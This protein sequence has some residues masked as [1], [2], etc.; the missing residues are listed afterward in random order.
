[1]TPRNVVRAW[2]NIHFA[3]IARW[4]MLTLAGWLAYVLLR[5]LWTIVY[6]GVPIYDWLWYFPIIALLVALPVYMAWP[7]PRSRPV[8]LTFAGLLI[9]AFIGYNGFGQVVRLQVGRV[10][11]IP[12]SFWAYQD[13]FH[14]SETILKDLQAAGGC[15]YL[16]PGGSPFEGEHG[17]VLAVGM[18]R[19]AEYDIEVYLM[20]PASDFLSVPVHREWIGNANAAAAFIQAKGLTNVRGL[21]GDAE[22]P[23]NVPMDFVGTGQTQFSEAVLGLRDFIAGMHRKYPE[24]RIGVTATWPQYVDGFDGDSDLAV[25]MRSPVDPPGGWD[26]VNLMTYSSYLPSSWRAYYVYLLERGMARR[27]PVDN[28]SHLIGLVGGGFPWEPLLDFDDLVRD[29]RL[30]RALGV[31]EI[32]VFQLNGALKVFGEDFIRRLTAA[33][34]GPQPDKT[35]EVPFSRPASLIFYGVAFADALLDVR[36]PLGLLWIGWA[37]LS[38]IIVRRLR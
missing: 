9:L 29:A 18:R 8:F 23:M 4:L 15:I 30:S 35:V 1:M 12:I 14:A 37:I 32:V 6:L 21:I 17:E 34:N 25:V 26:F 20:P 38:G 33:V 11:P 19:L 31:R 22:P 24:L 13:F 16:D 7:L 2:R 28:V 5:A 36:S 10:E 3:G 27:Y